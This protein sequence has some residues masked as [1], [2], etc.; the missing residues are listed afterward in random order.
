MQRVHV[1]EVPNRVVDVETALL[2][3]DLLNFS[4]YFTRWRRCSISNTSYATCAVNCVTI[5]ASLDRVL[6]GMFSEYWRI[7]WVAQSFF[8]S[9]A[10]FVVSC[11]LV[12]RTDCTLAWISALFHR[13]IEQ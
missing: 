6:E 1:P 11:V 13:W 8:A 12:Q 3:G 9:S 10:I 5:V 4:I 2:C 7:D